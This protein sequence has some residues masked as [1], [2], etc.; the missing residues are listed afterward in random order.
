MRLFLSRSARRALELGPPLAGDGA[1]SL[2]E[3]FLEARSLAGK[4]REGSEEAAEEERSGS[5]P[6]AG[7]LYGLD[8]IEEALRS[9]LERAASSH[10][11]L[12][13][14]LLNALERLFGENAVDSLLGAFEDDFL[15]EREPRSAPDGEAAAA[16]RR[17]LVGELLVFSVARSNPAAADLVDRLHPGVLVANPV[18]QALAAAVS[19][20]AAAL[21]EES[22]ELFESLR[23]PFAAEPESVADQLRWLLENWVEHAPA[24][25]E[26]IVPALDLIHEEQMERFPPG[27]GPI[28]APA[29]DHLEGGEVRYG[30]D[31]AWMAELVLAAKNT[32]V[33]LHQLSTRHGR[34]ISRLDQIPDEEL[35]RLAESGMTGLW[36]IG[37]WE[38]SKASAEIKR[39][40]GNPEAAGSAYSITAYRIADDLGGDEALDAL[41]ERA[42]RFGVRLSADMVPNHTAIDSEWLID[43]PERFLSTRVCPYPSYTFDGPDLSS[44]PRVGIYV[45]DHYFDRSDA[46]VVFRRVDRESG[47]VRYVYHGND[48]T[49]TPW[50]DTAQL[51][52]LNPETRAAVTATILDV[53]RRFPIIRFDAAMT[54]AREHVQRLWHPLPGSAGAIPSRA[55]HAIRQSEF[56]ARMPREFWRDVVD[57]A[58]SEAPDTLL[59]AEAFWLMEGYFVRNLGLHRVYNS[60]FM[61]MLRDGDNRG[62][63]KLVKEALDFDPQILRRY[64]NF[65]SNPDERT[66]IEQFGNGDRYLGAAM[67]LATMPGLPM[68]AHGQIEGLTERYGMEYRRSYVEEEPDRALVD[69][70]ERKI[71]PLLRL[72][73]SFA[74]VE[75]FA[76]LDF[77][78]RDG[79][80]IED[81]LAFSHGNGEERSLAVF[82]N[83][84]GPTRGALRFDHS[85]SEGLWTVR[86]FLSGRHF[87]R[88]GSELRERGFEL[89][90]GGHESLVLTGLR[91]V[92]GEPA[93]LRELAEFAGLRGLSTLEGLA[94]EMAMARAGESFSQLL[95]SLAAAIEGRTPDHEALLA[96]R[97]ELERQLERAGATRR[98]DGA[99]VPQ[100][101]DWLGA[102]SRLAELE[103]NFAWPETERMLTALDRYIAGAGESAGARGV[104]AALVLLGHLSGRWS[105]GLAG[106]EPGRRARHLSAPADGQ[107]P[108][109]HGDHGREAT[110]IVELAR[111]DGWLEASPPPGRREA[112]ALLAGLRESEAGRF[113]LGRHADD[114]RTSEAEIERLLK[115]RATSAALGWLASGA[116]R[117]EQADAVA[118]WCD[119]ADR[120]Q[121]ALADGDYRL[122]AAL[123]RFSG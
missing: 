64:V 59:M 14:D 108:D 92:S 85:A 102:V 87:L 4:L 37:L 50:N 83:Q 35:G 74:D 110:E 43:H 47:E 105:S 109:R 80:V 24:L 56:D 21:P 72:R 116:G 121:A 5:P 113:L 17:E 49:G 29:F 81:V 71:F 104:L 84:P 119:A 62:Y 7:E 93:Q 11:A 115:W 61:H 123:D 68:F 57:R 101:D 26:K 23:E 75:R 18:Y 12:L 39:L 63:R 27:P 79:S 90:L 44:D 36:L 46:A 42:S 66:A 22:G 10:P 6:S 58:E 1:V 28:E 2:S 51:D 97:R 77:T 120:L 67:L 52:Y 98:A 60:A 34:E 103:K 48:G 107:S 41:R 100:L 122:E 20:E 114:D 15:P 117:G 118:G 91:P 78:D 32:H 88:H 33:W 45:E 76:V 19:G 89:D 53:A 69:L 99:D 3:G 112:A 86:D 106:L 30:S 9:F 13:D 96:E 16:R 65:L 95:A 94:K 82:N 25:E 55:E 73:G 54:L 70:H 31:H 8:R 40:C 111:I 38:R